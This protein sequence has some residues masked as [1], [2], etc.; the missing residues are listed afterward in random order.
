MDVINPNLLTKIT[1]NRKILEQARKNL[2][3]FHTEEDKI[4]ASTLPMV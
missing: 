4:T 3:L 1:S 2:K